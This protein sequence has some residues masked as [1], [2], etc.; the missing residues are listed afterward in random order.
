MTSKQLDFRVT[1]KAATARL[2]LPFKLLAPYLSIVLLT[3][4]TLL[5]VDDAGSARGY[6]WLTLVNGVAYLIVAIAVFFLYGAELR[7]E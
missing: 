2:R 5:A 4:G 7:R 6:Y 1:P 3:A